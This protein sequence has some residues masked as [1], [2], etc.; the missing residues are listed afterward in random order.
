MKPKVT[1]T[2]LNLIGK[3]LQLKKVFIISLRESS[4]E[5]LL[6]KLI[7]HFIGWHPLIL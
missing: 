6:L 2:I 1:A 3:N 4:I 7:K 5:L